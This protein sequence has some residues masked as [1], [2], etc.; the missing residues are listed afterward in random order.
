MVACA[1]RPPPIGGPV[2]THWART[3]QRASE[4]FRHA[5]AAPT[6]A[7]SLL[8]MAAWM[9]CTEHPALTECLVVSGAAGMWEHSAFHRVFSR[10][11][12]DLDVLARLWLAALSERLTAGELWLRFMIDD[13]FGTRR[14]SRPTASA[15]TSMRWAPPARA[16]PSPSATSG[17]PAISPSRCPSRLRRS[18]PVAFDRPRVFRTGVLAKRMKAS[19]GDTLTR[20]LDDS[21]AMVRSLVMRGHPMV[22][23]T[24]ADPRRLYRSHDGVF[25]TQWV[26]SL[27]RMPRVLAAMVGRVPDAGCRASSTSA[28][29]LGTWRSA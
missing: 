5:F 19:K 3:F 10:R 16:R 15:H 26:L 17:G 29:R 28:L 27:A 21:A 9:L 25:P 22:T 23:P 20:I 8:L 2:P 4:V 24:H 11:R 1:T 6:F 18:P 13:T 7:R 12:W 14:A